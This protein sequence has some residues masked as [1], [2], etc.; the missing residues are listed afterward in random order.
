[1]SHRFTPTF[2]V[3]ALGGVSITKTDIPD[4]RTT[5]FRGDLALSK[6]FERGTASLV[7]RQSVL[8]GTQGNEPIDAKQLSLLYAVPLSPRWDFSIT[9]AYGLYKS[10]D[11]T[12][13]NKRDIT[14]SAEVSYKLARY[15]S[16]LA[17]YSYT[18]S[19]DKNNSVNSYQNNVFLIGIK[20]FTEAK[21]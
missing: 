11:D 14:G 9:G 18:D 10:V 13:Q 6:T 1:M 3:E 7:Y 17:S 21:L 20:L 12:S 8:P 4:N 2:S 19:K 5:G 15:A 16:A